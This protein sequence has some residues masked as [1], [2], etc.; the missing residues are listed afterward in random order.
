MKLR[1]LWDIAVLRLR[2]LVGKAQVE[3]ELDRELRF[4]FEVTF[5]GV[6]LVAVGATALACYLPARRAADA[7][8]MRS[9]RSE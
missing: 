2:S 9:L 1:R 6:A 7:D 5:A 3:R 4:H 8:P